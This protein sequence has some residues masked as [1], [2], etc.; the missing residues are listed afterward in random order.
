VRRGQVLS[1]PN[2]VK[3]YKKFKAEV[4]VLTEKEGGRHTPFFTHYRCMMM[5]AMMIMMLLLMRMVVAM[6]IMHR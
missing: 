3:T 1:A 5:I 2:T 6:M 4:Y